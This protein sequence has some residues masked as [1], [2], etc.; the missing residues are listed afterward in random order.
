MYKLEDIKSIHL[1]ITNKCQA[2]CPMC[3]RRIHG[4]ILNPLFNLSEITLEQFKEWFPLD[5]LAQL[6]RL[7]MC[8]NLGD[9]IIAKDCLNIFEYV[10]SV[11]KNINLS[12]HT[13]GSARSTRFWQGI[14]K[15]GVR[16]VFGIDGLADTHSLY[17]IDT[18]Y[19]FIIENAKVFI[20][21]GGLAEWH[22]LAFE[23]NEHQIVECKD[24]AYLLG[25]NNFSVKHTSRFTEDKFHVLNESGQT[26]HILRPTKH[27]K[28]TVIKIKDAL[29]KPAKISCKAKRSYEIY[30]S[31]E[32]VV[33]PCCWIELSWGIPHWPKIIDYKDQIGD[34][35]NLNNS[36]LI[37]IFNS[38]YFEKIEST[39]SNTPLMTCSEQCGNFDKMGAQFEH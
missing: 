13:N 35:P 33:T 29:E 5:F 3:P 10:R 36:T 38:N 6:D 2:R 15:A 30:V 22:M 39:W 21:A 37:E 16:V 4:G 24:T 7:T 1:E 18:D 12:M 25:F 11:N 8:G 31:A 32:G 27:S 17:R 23:H 14:A 9:P 20:Q 19:N 28:Q 34:F 26:T